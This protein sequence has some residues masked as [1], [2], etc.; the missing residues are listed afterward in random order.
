MLQVIYNWII[1]NQ[2]WFFD[3]LGVVLLTGIVTFIA[4]IVQSKRRNDNIA[5]SQSG[6]DGSINFQ[7]GRDL[8]ISS[9]KEGKNVRKKKSNGR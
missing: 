9:N 3:G 8:K 5:Q 4:K 6:G 1:D 7:I 2:E